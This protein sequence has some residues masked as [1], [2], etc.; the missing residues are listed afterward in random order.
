MKQLIYGVIFC[1]SGVQSDFSDV[2]PRLR[3]LCEVMSPHL[4]TTLTTGLL[5]QDYAVSCGHGDGGWS[6]KRGEKGGSVAIGEGGSSGKG[7]GMAR[8]REGGSCRKG[9]GGA[10]CVRACRYTYSPP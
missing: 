2:S 3:E 5:T 6:G 8:V 10:R 4:L 1:M 7:G 9:A